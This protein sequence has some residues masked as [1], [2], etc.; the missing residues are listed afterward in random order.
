MAALPRGVFIISIDVEF[1][2]G[3][4]DRP[5]RDACWALE[6]NGREIIQRLLDL[7]A[8]RDI[9][10]TWALVGH[11]F[12]ENCAA[13]ERPH[14]EIRRPETPWHEGDWYRFDPQGDARDHPQWYAPDVVHSILRASPA[15][16]IASHSF[17]HILFG[18]P[19]CSREAAEDDLNAARK[20][21]AQQHVTLRSIVFPR[22]S[23]GHLDLVREAGFVCFRG[24]DPVFYRDWKGLAKRVAH[25]LEDF[26]AITPPQARPAMEDGL[27]NLPGTMMLQGHEGVRALIPPG[28]RRRRAIKGLQQAASKRSLFHLWFHPSN[29]ATA[30]DLAFAELE[31]ITAEARRLRAAGSIEILTMAQLS[32]RLALEAAEVCAA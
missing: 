27:W 17:G 21:A 2:W 31:E 3:R 9:P 20:A 22:N 32:E 6:Q 10:A 8:R 29:L 14:P 7:F 28:A 5:D 18:H 13:G 26:L 16:E 15:H 4:F 11:L 19:G 30:P 25:Y 24:K 23:Q 1:N 12:L